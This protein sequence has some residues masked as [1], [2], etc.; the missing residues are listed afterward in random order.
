MFCCDGVTGEFTTFPP[1]HFQLGSSIYFNSSFKQAHHTTHILKKAGGLCS[2][3][4]VQHLVLL[5]IKNNSA[6]YLPLFPI[7]IYFG[8]VTFILSAAGTTFPIRENIFVFL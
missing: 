8:K 4:W 5:S 6:D 7:P 2:Q 1:S 3:K